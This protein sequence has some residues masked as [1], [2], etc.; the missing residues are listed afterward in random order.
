MLGAKYAAL[1][2]LY[3][4]TLKPKVGSFSSG[5]SSAPIESRFQWL[6][7]RLYVKQHASA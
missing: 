2:E 6:A 1:S 3:C 4:R 5:S 7:N